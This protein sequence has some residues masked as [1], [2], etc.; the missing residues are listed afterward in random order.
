MLEEL[1]EAL[2]REVQNISREELI[3]VFESMKR[4]VGLCLQQE[5]GHIEHLL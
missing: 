2:I 1:E 5:G 3:Q 4:R